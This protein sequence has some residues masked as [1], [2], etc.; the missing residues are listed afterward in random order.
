MALRI[1]IGAGRV[2]L[3]QQMLIESGLWPPLDVF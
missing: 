2:R 1:S 3:A